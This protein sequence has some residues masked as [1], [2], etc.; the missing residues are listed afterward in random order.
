MENS[1]DLIL[2]ALKLLKCNQKTLAEKLSVSATQITKWKS[3]EYMSIDMREKM[4]DILDLKG[5]SPNMVL[6]SGSVESAIEWMSLIHHLASLVSDLSETGYVTRPLSD[7]DELELLGWSTFFTLKEM[8]VT[9]PSSFPDELKNIDKLYDNNSDCEK[10]DN[11]IT[12]N[13]YSSLI[14]NIFLKLNDVYGFYAA[15][16]SELMCNEKLDLFDTDAC[17]LE[18]S[19]IDLAASKLDGEHT[20]LATNF[21]SFRFKT[22]QNFEKWLMIIKLSAIQHNVPLRAELLD[23][24]NQ[25]PDALCHD[26]ERESLGINKRQLHPDIYMNELLVG[27]RTMREVLPLILEKLGI[28]KDIEADEQ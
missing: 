4:D 5:M 2:L 13:P 27:M 1:A 9:L 24:I 16:I 3:G 19:L 11:I 7:D 14:Y 25:S 6:M 20:G 26:A 17:E 18:T 23:L 8:G 22:N 10:A 28:D 21:L 12:G 15:Y